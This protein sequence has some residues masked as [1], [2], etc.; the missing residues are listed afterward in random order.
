MCG[1]GLVMDFVE[2][3]LAALQNAPLAASVIADAV[4]SHPVGYGS[5]NVVT[6]L[7]QVALAVSV[8]AATA[9]ASA[10]AT[11]PVAGFGAYQAWAGMVQLGL[12]ANGGDPGAI[13]GSAASQLASSFPNDPF[14][15]DLARGMR[16]AEVLLPLG[17]GKAVGASAC[18]QYTFEEY[19]DMA[20]HLDVGTGRSQAVF[21]SG[22][23]NRALA[24]HFAKQ[25]GKLTLEMTSGGRWMDEQRLFDRLP[26]H[27][28]RAVWV[29]LSARFSNGASGS[30]VGF[31]KDASPTGVFNRIE[32]PLLR[33]NPLVLNVVTGGQ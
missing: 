27:E 14:A 29:E 25:N 4:A 5:A 18:R 9:G 20:R 7:G 13:S 12:Y 28:A 15:Q 19:M 10:P 22:K 17:L 31:V 11:V 16:A 2:K 32:Y 8:T 6:G 21:W 23:G 33:S 24:E 3:D 30:V 26:S 1:D